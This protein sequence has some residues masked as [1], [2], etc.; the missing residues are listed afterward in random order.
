MYKYSKDGISVLSVLDARRAKKSGLFPVKIQVIHNRRQ[1]YY[2][3]GQELSREDWANLAESKSRRLTEARSNIENSFSIIK[4]QVEALA[5]RGDFAFDL[6][7]VR[8]G[9]CSTATVNAAIKAKTEELKRNGQAGTYRS[10]HALLTAV[11]EF[12]GKDIPFSAVTVDWLN[13]CGRFWTGQKK[14]KSTL[15]VYFKMLKAIMNR[16]KADGII[17][18][19]HFPFGR[20]RFEI[21]SA[22][23]RKLALTLEQIKRLVTYTDGREETELYRDMWFFS[24]LCNGI[25]FRDMLYLTYGNIVGGEICFV[26]AKT[27]NTSKQV[28]TIRAVLTPEMRKSWTAGATPTTETPARSSSSS[29][30]GRRTAS[31]PSTLSI[32]SYRNATRYWAG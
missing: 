24:Y 4:G 13:R 18:E 22:E 3:T 8:L 26:R 1:K 27:M 29:P 11:E 12:A 14:S 25:N 15:S 19:A 10:Y 20:N 32:R 31:P 5:E 17:K 28:R 6:L 21:P 30:R 9:R 7:S 23:G 16:A 2:S